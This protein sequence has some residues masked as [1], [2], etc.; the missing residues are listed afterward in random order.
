MTAATTGTVSAEQFRE[1]M[2]AHP[3]S[4]AVI[5]T[6]DEQGTPHGF[7]CTALCAVSLDPPMLLVCAANTGRTLP[8]LTRSGHFAVNLLHTRGQ[9][10]AEAFTSR[11][12]DRFSAVPWR[13]A[14]G[15][16]LPLLEQDAHT[17]AEC[18]VVRLDPAGDHTIVLGEVVRTGSCGDPAQALLYGLRTYATWPP[19]TETTPRD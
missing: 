10:A 6:I 17:V 4:V 1:L 8:V 5:T 16:G 12:A 18:R 19:A 15:S 3:S 13:P 11:T 7:T 2:G 14:P 9:R